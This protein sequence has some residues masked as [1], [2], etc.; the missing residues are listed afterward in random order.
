MIDTTSPSSACV[1]GRRDCQ[2]IAPSL[3]TRDVLVEAVAGLS[4]YSGAS[5]PLMR[6]GPSPKS[7][8]T[9]S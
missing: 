7:S 3:V 4:A 9:L 8:N 5:G 1:D 6:V 2:S